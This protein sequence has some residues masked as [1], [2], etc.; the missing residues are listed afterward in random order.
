MQNRVAKDVLQVRVCAV[1]QQVVI[2]LRLPQ[3]R[4]KG[5]RV[6]TIVSIPWQ[7]K[8]LMTSLKYGSAK[9]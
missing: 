8:E 4:S 3:A 7:D 9:S 1:L 2:N 6:L 5:Q